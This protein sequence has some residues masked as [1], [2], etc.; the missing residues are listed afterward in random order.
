MDI[1]NL[2]RLEQQDSFIA[3]SCLVERPMSPVPK[4]EEIDIKVGIITG[5]L[6]PNSRCHYT[7]SLGHEWMFKICTSPSGKFN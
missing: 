5:S 7:N 6:N 1:F 2:H 3:E 4:K